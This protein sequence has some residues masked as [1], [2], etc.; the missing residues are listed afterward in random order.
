MLNNRRLIVIWQRLASLI[1]VGI[2]NDNKLHLIT[3]TFKMYF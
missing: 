3:S 1:T 2:V